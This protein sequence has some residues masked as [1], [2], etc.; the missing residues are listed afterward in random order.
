MRLSGVVLPG[1]SLSRFL[2]TWSISM[3][4]GLPPI[5]SPP[6]GPPKRL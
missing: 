2:M 4:L 5:E 6:K 1:S 3:I